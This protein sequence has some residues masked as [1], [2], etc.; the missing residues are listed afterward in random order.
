MGKTIMNR[1]TLTLATVLSLAFTQVTAQDFNKG[2]DAYDAGNYA[3]ALKEWRPLAEQGHAEAQR[4]IGEAYAEGK[5]VV[6]DFTEA[7]KWFLLSAKQGHPASQAS[8]GMMYAGGH[9]VEQNKTLGYMWLDISIDNFDVGSEYA[10]VPTMWK[11]ALS[12][13]MT[14]SEIYEAQRMSYACTK[15]LYSECRELFDFLP[16]AIKEEMSKL[17][18][19]SIESMIAD[20]LIGD[21]NDPNYAKNYGPDMA[22]AR[23]AIADGDYPKAISNFFFWGMLHGD[24][25]AQLML[26]ALAADGH[27]ELKPNYQKAKFYYTLAAEQNF[28]V[29]QLA[30]G[31]LYIDGKGVT[32][33]YK[34][35]LRWLKKAAI[36][37]LSEAQDKLGIL[38]SSGEGVELDY[39][40][41]F[42]WWMM[43]AKQ[44]NVDVQSDIGIMYEYGNGVSQSN[45]N[46]FMWYAIA[47][48]NGHIKAADY[49]DERTGFM[50][51]TDI[52][53]AKS[54]A[55]KC[56]KSNYK[57][58]G[59]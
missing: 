44:G 10:K 8:I 9:G 3:A 38:Y 31:E 33:N 17:F 34:Q 1:I 27:G 40:K 37:G 45:I 22:D 2:L 50:T 5:G 23:E 46:A 32:K 35:A 55:L 41:A 19:E 59:Y 28:A 21:P 42:K 18:Y 6:Q 53:K 56:I 24:A 36:Q 48:Y 15:S 14:A 12:N 43:A 26:G 52:S 29:A 20:G 49:R 57:K 13:Q 39:T 54:M 51:N 7:S 25:K 4:K 30:L 58:C 47:A 16:E 11:V